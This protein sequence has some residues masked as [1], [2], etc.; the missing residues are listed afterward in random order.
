MSRN[1]E[2][3]IN[4]IFNNAGIKINGSNPW[5]IKVHDP[6][7]FPRITSHT[8]VGFGEAY[9]EGWWDCEQLDTC[10]E[11]IFNSNL[12]NYGN[13]NVWQLFQFAYFYFQNRIL[14]PQS[15]K[16]AY[17]VGTV[18]Y[19][20]GNDLFLA[21][22]DPTMSYSCGYWKKASNL[23]QA[24]IDKLK[25]IC[26]K[27]EL[28]PG[29]KLLDIGC[30]WG[31]LAVFAAENYGVEVTGITISKQQY[32]YAIER[33]KNLPIKILF[34]DYRTPLP[35]KFDRL[36]SVGMFEHVGQKNYHE[37]MKIAA[38]TLD[39]DGLF[40][41]HTIGNNISASSTDP[42]LDKYI[43]PHG[44]LPSVKQIG[45]AIE[46]L[47][48]MEDWH[49]FGADYDKTLLA[50]HSKFVENWSLLKNKYDQRFYRMWKFYLLSCA[51]CFRARKIQLWQ[52]VLTKAGK[53][54][55]YHSF[56]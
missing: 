18:H 45:Q 41:L 30:G 37:F 52:I 29:M 16:K 11:K 38:K 36:V 53:A 1:V 55:G 6:R 27:L 23:E 46:N 51:G 24:Q 35:H 28:Q 43:F 21:M 4:T 2:K 47:F 34:Q 8:S 33:C 54:G 56:R 9:M 40:L 50:W 49:N 7:F 10:I 31:G 12:M 13:Q 44:M 19:D 42:W 26:E 22:L 3:F 32:D 17:D 14:N 20:L 48:V 39:D 5:D 25:L 15:I